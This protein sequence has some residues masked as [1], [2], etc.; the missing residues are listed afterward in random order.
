MADIETI[1][2]S[3][4]WLPIVTPFQHDEV[5]IDALQRLAEG[6]LEQEISGIVA[7]GTT[8]EAA[9]LT[10]GERLS[11]LHALL[12]VLGQRLPVMVGV[13][14]S[15][16]R[17]MI[18]EIHA[19]D[20]LELS[21]YL[22]PAPA[23]I[24]PEQAGLLWHFR[25]IAGSTERPIVLYDVPRR[26]GVSIL[27]ETVERLLEVPNIVAIKACTPASFAAL[28]RL[29]LSVM[30]GDDAAFMTCQRSGGAGGILASAHIYADQLAEI[31]EEASTGRLDH[32]QVLFERIRPAIEL[33]FST[34]NP[35]GIKA[36]LALQGKLESST[37]MPIVEASTALRTKLEQAMLTATQL[38]QAA[39]QDR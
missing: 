31:L 37:R 29:P 15:N 38:E 33:M 2:V 22:V 5:D 24:C 36:A 28:G 17:D 20:R 13:G 12:E 3:G 14:G 11:V 7:L 26:T 4:I 23:Y 19:V 27:P 6:Y 18:R 39:L 9:L 32:A 34:P 8:A 30:C 16:T 10:H 21:G 35:G 1:M 25:E